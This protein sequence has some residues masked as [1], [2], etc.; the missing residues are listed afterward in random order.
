MPDTLP[1]DA[2][3]VRGAGAS[4]D[5]GVIAWAPLPTGAAA[6]VSGEVD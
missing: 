5:A 1:A 3:A 2:L 6:A 4:G